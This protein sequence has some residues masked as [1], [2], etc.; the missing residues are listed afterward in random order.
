MA[1][2]PRFIR[3]ESRRPVDDFIQRLKVGLVGAACIFIGIGAL[4]WVMG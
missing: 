4:Q 3:R 1:D 2:I